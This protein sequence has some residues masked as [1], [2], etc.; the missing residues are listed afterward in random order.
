M[1]DLPQ[2][3]KARALIVYIAMSLDGYIATPEGDLD[4]LSTVAQ[5]GED[6]GYADFLQQVDTV[7]W[8]RKTYEKVLSFGGPLP[9]ADKRVYVLT[10]SRQGREGQVQFVDDLPGLV[11]SLQQEQEGLAIYCDGGGALV[12]ELL[13]LQCVDQLIISIIP[14]LLGDGIRLFQPPGPVQKLQLLYS[15]PFPSGLVQLCYAVASGAPRA[16]GA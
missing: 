1:H 7:L 11:R 9:H 15:K 4:F 10:K 6:Y 3:R 16:A 13:R 8:G 14:Q 2:T 12:S 5:E